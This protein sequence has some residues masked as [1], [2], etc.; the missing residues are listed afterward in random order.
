VLTAVY[1]LRVLRDPRAKE[2]LEVTRDRWKAI[3]FDN[4]QIV[5]ECEIALRELPKLEPEARQ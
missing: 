4:S 1:T 5:E 3:N 2:V